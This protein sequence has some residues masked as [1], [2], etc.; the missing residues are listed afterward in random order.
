MN[1]SELKKTPVRSYS[2]ISPIQEGNR[3]RTENCWH[4]SRFELVTVG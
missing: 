2:R 3:E 1:G 4:L